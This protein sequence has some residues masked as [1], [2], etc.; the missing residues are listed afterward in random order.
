M[1]SKSRGF[2]VWQDFVLARGEPTNPAILAT[3]IQ[4]QQGSVNPDNLGIETVADYFCHHFPHWMLDSIDQGEIKFIQP[5]NPSFYIDPMLM[6]NIEGEQLRDICANVIRGEKYAI[7][8][9]DSF[10]LDCYFDQCDSEEDLLIIHIDHHTDRGWMYGDLDLNR[11]NLKLSS[12]G[13]N[14][15]FHDSFECVNQLREKG[16]LH[17]GN[18]L[19]FMSASKRKVH[20]IFATDQIQEMSEIH[21]VSPNVVEDE[22]SRKITFFELS[23]KRQESSYLWQEGPVNCLAHMI[24]MAF[25]ESKFDKVMVHIDLDEYDNPWDGNSANE[26]NIEGSTSHVLKKLASDIDLISKTEPVFWHYCM[27]TGF[28]PAKHWKKV[29][30]FLEDYHD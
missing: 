3:P 22:Y 4:F 5:N 6:K 25:L 16:I 8:F 23:E 28:F 30:E 24:D 10:F 2:E 7:S 19:S 27:P 11:Q 20:V 14:L 26:T 9:E 29:I 1:E 21:S 18:F 15:I 12:T 13:E 17:Q